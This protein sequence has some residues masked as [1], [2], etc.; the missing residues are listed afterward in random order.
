MRTNACWK[1]V[2]AVAWE[3]GGGWS[4][5]VGHLAERGPKA[6]GRSAPLTQRNGAGAGGPN[7]P[8]TQRNGP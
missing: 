1:A 2:R 3:V 5:H 8:G 7:T 6:G 4:D